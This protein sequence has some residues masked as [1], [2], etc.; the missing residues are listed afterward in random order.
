MS[1]GGKESAARELFGPIRF[2]PV[3]ASAIP[4]RLE[5]FWALS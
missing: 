2:I 4:S 3:A 1:R 5:I